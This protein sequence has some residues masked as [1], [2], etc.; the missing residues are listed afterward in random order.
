MKSKFDTLMDKLLDYFYVSIG[1]IARKNYKTASKELKIKMTPPIEI[2][3]DIFPHSK[4]YPFVDVE[5][6]AEIMPYFNARTY[7]HIKQISG[8]TELIGE[9]KTI[10]MQKNNLIFE[11]ARILGFITGPPMRSKF[12]TSIRWIEENIDNFDYLLDLKLISEE[13]HEFRA[14]S[15][16]STNISQDKRDKSA[17]NGHGSRGKFFGQ[18]CSIG[19]GF[20][21]IPIIGITKAGNTADA[22]FFNDTVEYIQNLAL[23]TRKDVWAIT[24]DAGYS[25]TYIIEDIKVADSIL[26]IEINTRQS[27]LL[28]KLKNVGAK[29]QKL[30]KMAIKK[31]LSSEERRAWIKDTKQ[32]SKNAGK[33]I[34]Y[35]E[36]KSPSKNSFKI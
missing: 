34:S 30:S 3:I 27:K 13:I 25:S 12:F 18:K 19:C 1:E 29:L 14:I 26:F 31:G 4:I 11:L 23:L 24:A 28:K 16:D 22:A 6:R 35:D 33:F 17:S 9:T 10:K 32:Y 8:I 21:C 20:N 2:F 15:I 7:M 36:K 5:K